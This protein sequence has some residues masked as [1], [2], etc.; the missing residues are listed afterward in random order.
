MTNIAEG[1]VKVYRKWSDISSKVKAAVAGGVT[2]GGTTSVIAAINPDW[3]PDPWVV[4]LITLGGAVAAAWAKGET[5]KVSTIKADGSVV[6]NVTL[7]LPELD[8]PD[9]VRA[10]LDAQE[11]VG[12]D[13]A[14][15]PVGPDVVDDDE[16]KHLATS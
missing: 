10:Q 5:V 11:Q 16:P 14:E 2:T 13:E 6:E 4:G 12:T 9:W 3:H 15:Q 1:L 7:D 8:M